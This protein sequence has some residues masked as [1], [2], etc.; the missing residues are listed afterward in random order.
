VHPERLRMDLAAAVGRSSRHLAD[1]GD[2][3]CQPEK[4]KSRDDDNVVAFTIA[5]ANT[6][7]LSDFHNIDTDTTDD[8]TARPCFF[9]GRRFPLR[10]RGPPPTEVWPPPDTDDDDDR[11]RHSSCNRVS[12]D[13]SSVSACAPVRVVYGVLW[14]W[15][16]YIVF[17]ST[18]VFFFSQETRGDGQTT[19][20]TVD[21]DAV[22]L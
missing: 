11:G 18:L 15:L 1:L 19:T 20:S 3:W 8:V 10:A 21:T 9:S 2:G 5:V 13:F 17:P 22:P 16:L 14:L 7:S 6:T 4:R 12:R